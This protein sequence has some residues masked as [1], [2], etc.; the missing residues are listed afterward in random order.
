MPPLQTEG[1]RQVMH[2][3]LTYTQSTRGAY[4]SRHRLPTLALIT[5]DLGQLKLLSLMSKVRTSVCPSICPVTKPHM[6][7]LSPS[8]PP[9]VPSPPLQAIQ[10]K[11]KL[12]SP[13]RWTSPHLLRRSGSAVTPPTAV[14]EHEGEGEGE[15]TNGRGRERNGE[16]RCAAHAYIMAHLTHVTLPPVLTNFCKCK[17]TRT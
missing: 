10:L 2:P 3:T 6:C 4:T 15:G 8:L 13:T 14:M 9:P 17:W 5:R 7:S 1:S 12:G 16:R 11:I